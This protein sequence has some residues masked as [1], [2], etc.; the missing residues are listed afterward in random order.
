MGQRQRERNITTLS[1]AN[2]PFNTETKWEKGARSSVPHW[3]AKLLKHNLAN[4]TEFKTELILLCLK[5]EQ[6]Y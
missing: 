4:E 1:L 2:N 3:N 6:L 5:L